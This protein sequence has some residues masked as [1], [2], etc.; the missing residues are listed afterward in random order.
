MERKAVMALQNEV[1]V[2]LPGNKTLTS[3]PDRFDFLD[4]LLNNCH[5]FALGAAGNKYA[6]AEC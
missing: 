1:T 4:S 5:R 6:V 3:F 2:S